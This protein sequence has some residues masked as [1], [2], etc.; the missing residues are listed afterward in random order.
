MYRLMRIHVH[1]PKTRSRSTPVCNHIRRT[2]LD[3]WTNRVLLG[4]AQSYDDAHQLTYTSWFTDSNLSNA[5]SVEYTP[6]ATHESCKPTR[7]HDDLDTPCDP[8]VSF[9]T[10][11]AVRSSWLKQP[12]R[13]ASWTMRC[14]QIRWKDFSVNMT[15]RQITDAP[16]ASLYMA[17]IW[18]FFPIE[19]PAIVRIIH[20]DDLCNKKYKHESKQFFLIFV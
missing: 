19:R 12:D 20:R 8:F 3:E 7:L 9:S 11:R 15:G 17:P 16:W 5:M 4:T 2:M 18:F 10:S 13:T 6:M 1:P 14:K